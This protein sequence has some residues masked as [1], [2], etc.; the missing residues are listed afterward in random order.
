[1]SFLR[2][3]WSRL[4]LA[5]AS[6]IV[7]LLVSEVMLTVAAGLSPGLA[8]LLSRQPA[9]ALED[10]RLGHRP[11]PLHPE[12]D[13]RGFRNTG[14]L[15]SPV[16]VL[17]MGDSQTYGHKVLRFQAWPQVLG[18]TEDWP[19]YN[20]A[21]GG[22]GPIQ[23]LLLMEEAKP[24]APR[25]VIEA[26]YS[27][28][29][30]YD[31]Y[32]MVWEVGQRRDLATPDPALGPI[33]SSLPP[34]D[35]S[36]TAPMPPPTPH[37]QHS[38]L[39]EWLAQR[40]R[41]Y[42]VLRAARRSRAARRQLAEHSP[43]NFTDWSAVVASTDDPERFLQFEAGELRTV[44]TPRWRLLALDTTDP[45]I[46]EGENIAE[47]ALAE[48]ERQ[49]AQQGSAFVVLVIPTKELVFRPWVKPGLNEDYDR[50]TTLEA[51]ALERLHEALAARGIPVIEA[52]PDL[53]A[54]LAQ[55]SS[56]YPI[57]ANSHTNEIGHQ[58]IAELVRRALRDLFP[59]I[60]DA[61]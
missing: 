58:V 48:L 33:F 38:D 12:H 36:G 59:E 42:G 43:H 61:C 14:T 45:R 7:A 24:L 46:A 32:H 54:S 56:P 18:R 22:W 1:M 30:F 19:V 51:S 2:G 40:S 17:A 26:F 8:Y 49:A 34:L 60:T 37:T 50:L 28:N 3:L 15:R 41:L 10:P 11:H 20:M 52:L 31:A 13:G 39:R 21:F 47:R 44:F 35:F 29:D 23:S 53:R 6:T 55:G 27:G 5:A 57:T 9:R 16:C 4:I 25:I